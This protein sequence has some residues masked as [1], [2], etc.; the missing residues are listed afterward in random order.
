MTNSMDGSDPPRKRDRHG[1]TAPPGSRSACE[2]HQCKGY[3]QQL[4]NSCRSTEGRPR[5][6]L[7]DTTWLSGA[8]PLIYRWLQDWNTGA[9]LHG[10]WNWRFRRRA[11]AVPLGEGTRSRC[12]SH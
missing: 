12:G 11:L 9:L 10:P 5:N 7:P 2:D 3:G 8:H 6:R 4:I 1:R